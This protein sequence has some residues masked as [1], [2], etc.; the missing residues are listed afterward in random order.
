[1]TLETD[2]SVGSRRAFL[3]ASV[4]EY[5]HRHRQVGACRR[6]EIGELACQKQRRTLVPNIHSVGHSRRG[7]KY[8][9]KDFIQLQWKNIESPWAASLLEQNYALGR[10][11]GWHPVAVLGPKKS[12]ELIHWRKDCFSFPCS[13]C[14]SKRVACPF[15]LPY[16]MT[17]CNG[18]GT[19]YFLLPLPQ[20]GEIWERLREPWKAGETEEKSSA[21]KGKHSLEPMSKSCVA[22]PKGRVPV[23]TPCPKTWASAQRHPGTEDSK[24]EIIQQYKCGH[25]F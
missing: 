18:S 15:S 23:Y 10:L 17:E 12:T 21:S 11:I 7:H 16:G 1:M 2:M 19:Y 4:E 8:K 25:Y 9:A 13:S 24:L 22:S 5:K 3:K 14:G 20:T 6:K